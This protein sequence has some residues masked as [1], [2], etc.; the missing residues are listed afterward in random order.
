M[1]RFIIVLQTANNTN[2][3]EFTFQYGQIYYCNSTSN[4]N[5]DVSI[6]IPIWLDLLLKMG[7]AGMITKAAF[8]FQYGQIYYD[9]HA[10]FVPTRLLIYIPIW[11]DLLF[12][13]YISYIL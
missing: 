10:F 5:L 13:C 3:R 11:L 9:I 1:V 6:Y 4:Y 2:E 8:T 12:L 7:D